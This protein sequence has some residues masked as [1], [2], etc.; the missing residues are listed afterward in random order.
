[1]FGKKL[2][3]QLKVTGKDNRHVDLSNTDIT[4]LDVFMNLYYKIFE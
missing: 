3:L 2:I 1:M 4:S